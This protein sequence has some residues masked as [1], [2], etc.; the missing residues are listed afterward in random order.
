MDLL[1]IL[2]IILALFLLIEFSKHFLFTSAAKLIVI[3]IILSIVFLIILGS[4][5]SENL[6]KT[7]SEFINTGAAIVDS[8]QEQD[9]FSTIKEKINNLKESI[10]KK[11]T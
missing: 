2:I 11:D 10:F 9:F 3:F 8:I 1:T 5:K 4:L 7:D 6:L